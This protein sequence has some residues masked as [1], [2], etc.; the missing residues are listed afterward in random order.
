MPES[1]Q[2]KLENKNIEIVL[3]QSK[4]RIKKGLSELMISI[5]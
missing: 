1:K 3:R 2:K 4:S 5:I